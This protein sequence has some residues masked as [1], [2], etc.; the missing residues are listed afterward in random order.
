MGISG[1]R[2]EPPASVAPFE[3]LWFHEGP[4][5]TRDS[6]RLEGPREGGGWYGRRDH[7]TGEDESDTGTKGADDPSSGGAPETDAGV[8]VSNERACR[9]AL[10]IGGYGA[11]CKKPEGG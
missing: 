8:E 2:V 6:D 1:A 9:R 3:T 10:V 4:V 7:P 11:K 5:P